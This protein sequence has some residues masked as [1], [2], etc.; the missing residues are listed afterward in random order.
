MHA[1]YSPTNTNHRE[2]KKHETPNKI[3][4]ILPIDQTI[5]QIYITTP[6]NRL[7]ENQHT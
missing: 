5:D 6:R 7:H 2:K 3:D 1:N 4:Q